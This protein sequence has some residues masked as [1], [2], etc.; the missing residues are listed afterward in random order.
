MVE[1]QFLI[2]LTTIFISLV[3]SLISLVITKENKTSEFRASWI[4]DLRAEISTYLS[5][6][7]EFKTAWFLF[8]ERKETDYNLFFTENL[9]KMKDIRKYR[10]IIVFRLNDNDDA[11]L[12][13]SIKEI[14]YIL[15]D[16][17]KIDNDK[18]YEKE[19]NYIVKETKILLKGEWEKVKLGEKFFSKMKKIF[20]IFSPISF[21]II[22]GIG[23]VNY[24]NKEKRTIENNYI[25][26]QTL[27]NYEF[28]Y[29]KGNISLD[30]KYNDK[31][32][33]NLYNF[34]KKQKS[35]NTKFYITIIGYSSN[36]LIKD[37]D[38]ISNNYEL[39]IAR[40]NNMK[41]EI[42]EILVNLNINR[43]NVFFNVYGYSNE[44]FNEIVEN[45]LKRKVL[46]K[47]DEISEINSLI[48]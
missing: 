27:K 33:E 40:A 39:S 34:F 31:N 8:T 25:I 2:A 15:E 38:K 28:Y 11:K 17:K 19:H 24:Y 26:N 16:P 7:H 20:L 14:N 32:Y 29:D 47:I 21:L 13:K 36:E 3:V 9:E 10:E 6:I 23:F 37:K 35:F 1:T 18:L 46:I 41:K 48:K 42:E 30:K 5:L 22:V 12:I 45:D 43:T 4:N 44:M